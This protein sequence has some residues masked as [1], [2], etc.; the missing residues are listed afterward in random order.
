MAK[1]FPLKELEAR[2]RALVAESEVY[3]QTLILEV[4]NVRLYGARMRR[5]FYVLRLANPLVMLVGS[6]VGSRLFGAGGKGKRRSKLVR[7]LIGLRLLRQVWPMVRDYSR[8]RLARSARTAETAAG[9]G[10]SRVANS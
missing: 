6:F 1:V 5:T 9:D 8:Q 10:R 3:R 4:Q 7:L 2:K